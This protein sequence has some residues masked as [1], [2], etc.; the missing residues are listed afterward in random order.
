M[1]KDT[2]L[3]GISSTEVMKKFIREGPSLTLEKG[4][5]S[6]KLEDG[7]TLQIKASHITP[8]HKLDQYMICKDSRKLG[9]N[10]AASMRGGNSTVGLC[11]SNQGS[12]SYNNN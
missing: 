4:K 3:C 9:S 10:I 2:F 1:T 12:G 11:T 8:M 7:V 6:A 5:A